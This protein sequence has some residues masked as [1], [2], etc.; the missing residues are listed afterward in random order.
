MFSPFA[1]NADGIEVAATQWY[2]F[3]KAKN[4]SQLLQQT[5][6]KILKKK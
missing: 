6:P 5:K 3:E 4:T 2:L 1:F